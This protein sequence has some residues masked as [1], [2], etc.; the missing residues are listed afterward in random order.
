M[1]DQRRKIEVPATLEGIRR[2]AD[3]SASLRFTSTQEITVPEMAALDSLYQSGGWLLFAENQINYADIPK[4][5][6][7]HDGKTQGQRLRGVFF[8]SWEKNTDQTEDFEAYYRRR[9]EKL[10]AYVKQELED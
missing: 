2:L 4:D 7:P 5:D 10:I 6:A 9:M 1:A 8:R 3:R